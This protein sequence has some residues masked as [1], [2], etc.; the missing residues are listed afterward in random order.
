MNWKLFFSAFFTLF[1]AE[2]GDKTQL[3]VFCMSADKKQPI[4]IFLG[5]S[6]ALILVTF[7]G[8]FF[9][10]YI[11]RYIPQHIIKFIAGCLFIGIGIF[12]LK[13]SFMELSK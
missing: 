11:S 12:V 3:A 9:G 5:A 2:L 7:L 6:L 8:A 1:I 13:E 10:E 4:P